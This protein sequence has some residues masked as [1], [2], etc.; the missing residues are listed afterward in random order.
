[1]PGLKVESQN[2]LKFLRVYLPRSVN[3]AMESGVGTLAQY[4]SNFASTPAFV[5]VDIENF[6]LP[7][8]LP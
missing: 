4:S 8:E 6:P 2:Y 7:V 5:S 1:M 3:S